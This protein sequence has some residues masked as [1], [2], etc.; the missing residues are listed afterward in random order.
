MSKEL[1]K[2]QLTRMAWLTELRRQGHRKCT[3][4]LFR[5]NR[6]CALGLLAE[7]GNFDAYDFYEIGALAGLN[8]EQTDLVWKMNDGWDPPDGP[9][10]PQHT[11]AEI[12]SEVEGWF[13]V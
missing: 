1:D 13:R 10:I 7:V 2:T 3:G 5:G 6:A 11:F 9:S 8:D 12:A 4:L